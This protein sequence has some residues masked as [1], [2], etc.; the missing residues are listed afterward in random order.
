MDTMT[1]ENVK[2]FSGISCSRGVWKIYNLLLKTNKAAL[3]AQNGFMARKTEIK[4]G[5]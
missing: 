2:E 5:Q 1:G 3:F 4:E